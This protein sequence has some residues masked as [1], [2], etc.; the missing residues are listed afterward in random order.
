MSDQIKNILTNLKPKDEIKEQK[1]DKISQITSN[2]NVTTSG[3]F[4]TFITISFLAFLI[5][6]IYVFTTNTN[7]IKVM[8]KHEVRILDK[9]TFI[10]NNQANEI[11]ALVKQIA[12]YQ[13]KSPLTVHNELKKMFNY[14]RYR[15]IDV[16]T[17]EKVIAY[18][19]GQSVNK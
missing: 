12:T 1:V 17:Y 19:K 10:T 15:E 8:P 16:A 7:S 11:K 4:L 13:N 5:V 2:I 14:Y 9:S 18:L 3:N 6:V